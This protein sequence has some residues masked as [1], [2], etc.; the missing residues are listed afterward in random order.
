MR[1]SARVRA[2]EPHDVTSLFQLK[3]KLDSEHNA[4]F[5]IRATPDDWLRDGFGPDAQFTAFVAEENSRL[6]GMITCSERYYTGWAGS[7]MCIQD[8]FVEPSMRR[9]GFGR[10]LLACVARHALER[11]CPMVELALQTGN[12]A[13]RLY[14]RSGFERVERCSVYVAGLQAMTMLAGSLPALPWNKFMQLR[15]SG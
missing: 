4:D 13:S 1:P 5:S 14:R 3:L 10:L 12:R 9:Q 7:A 6:F 2:A 11:E 8:F 15:R